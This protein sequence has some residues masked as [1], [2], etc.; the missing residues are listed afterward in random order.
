MKHSQLQSSHIA[1]AT[2]AKCIRHIHSETQWMD[3]TERIGWD[4]QAYAK[5][6]T[7]HTLHSIW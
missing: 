7:S 6:G 4:P 1:Y 3:K 2:L 5:N